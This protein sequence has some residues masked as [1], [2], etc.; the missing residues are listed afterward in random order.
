MASFL[1]DCSQPWLDFCWNINID[2]SLLEG[3]TGEWECVEEE[4]EQERQ[5][6]STKGT[7]VASKIGLTPIS[8]D[9]PKRWVAWRQLAWSNLGWSHLQMGLPDCDLS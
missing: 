5:G 6:F 7:G 8:L 9:E 3:L 1:H 2:V 4:L